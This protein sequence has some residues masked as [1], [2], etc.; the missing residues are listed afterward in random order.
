MSLRDVALLILA[1][2]L[3][4]P[5]SG[6]SSL[7]EQTSQSVIQRQ[8]LGAAASCEG[9]ASLTLSGATITLA[10]AIDAGA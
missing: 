6:Q 7:N 3:T 2:G 8:P 9:L 10:R 1:A 5:V 4:G